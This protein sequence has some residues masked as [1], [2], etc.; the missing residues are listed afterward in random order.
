MLRG[1]ARLA[2]YVRSSPGLATS[3]LIPAPGLSS[4]AFI[5]VACVI[6]HLVVYVRRVFD[7]ISV[8]ERI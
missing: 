4:D 1:R 2:D 6:P 8:R 3:I 5:A 7:N